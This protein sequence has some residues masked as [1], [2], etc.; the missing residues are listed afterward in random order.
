MTILKY[1]I[2]PE[3]LHRNYYFYYKKMVILKYQFLKNI[4]II[5]K[6]LNTLQIKNKSLSSFQYHNNLNSNELL[7]HY[8]NYYKMYV[9]IVNIIILVV[10]IK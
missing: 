4:S 10:F 1:K 7:F 6:L 8:P 2:K 5:L 9:G 3:S